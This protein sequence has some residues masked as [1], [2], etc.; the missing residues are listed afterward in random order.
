[1]VGDIMG[2]SRARRARESLGQPQAGPSA[3]SGS[4]RF[5]GTEAGPPPAYRAHPVPPRRLAVITNNGRTCRDDFCVRSKLF[6]LFRY[7]YRLTQ[8]LRCLLSR[9][10]N[11]VGPHRLCRAVAQGRSPRDARLLAAPARPIAKGAGCGRPRH[12]PQGWRRGSTRSIRYPLIPR[13]PRWPLEDLWS[14]VHGL[15]VAW[16]CQERR[17]AARNRWRRSPK[18]NREPSRTPRYRCSYRAGRSRA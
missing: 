1:M 14:A 18:R 3:G 15:P 11:G 16:L 10:M 7:Y 4:S 8:R 5:Q 9:E 6:Q 12:G 13:S 17:Y 2:S